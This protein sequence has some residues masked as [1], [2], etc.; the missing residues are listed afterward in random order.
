MENHSSEVNRE[1]DK[2]KKME[3]DWT[4]I[5]QI[6]RSN[7]EKALDWNPQGYRLRGTAEE[8][9]AKDNRRWNKKHKKIMERGQGDNW[10]SECLE[11][12]HGCPM[13]H[14]D[15]KDLMNPIT[16][17][18]GPWGFHEAEALRFNDKWHM[19]VVRLS[20]LCTSCLSPQEMFLVLASVRGWVDPR[21]I[22]RLEGLCQWNIRTPS[23]IEPATVQLVAQCLNQLHHH[24]PIL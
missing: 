15:W 4:H 22:V 21:A 7:R 19:K 5:M 11:A 14:K 18:D 1:S 8:N 9:V 24:V 17:L 12:L 3:L 2:K 23:G 6:S 13:L 16:G 10:R 20:A